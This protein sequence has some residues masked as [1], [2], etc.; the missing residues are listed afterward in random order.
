MDN[1]LHFLNERA[2]LEFHSGDEGGIKIVVFS[3]GCL[4]PGLPRQKLFKNPRP[5]ASR[6]LCGSCA[7]GKG[8]SAAVA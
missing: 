6:Q 4:K 2:V 3:I 7:L 5:L 8:V 1:L